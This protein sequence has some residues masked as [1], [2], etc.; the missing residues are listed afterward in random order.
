MVRWLVAAAA[1]VLVAGCGRERAKHGRVEV[2]IWS[3]WT[4]EEAKSFQTLVDDFNRR[5][6]GI[7][8]HNLGGVTDNTK[9]VRAITAGVPPDLF[10]VW[11]AADVGPLAH[12]G[13]VRDLSAEYR[14]SGLKDADFVPGALRLCRDGNRLI[15]LPLLLDTN[16]LLWNKAAFRAA[17]L[18]PDRPPRTLQELKDHA[19]RLTKKDANGN[20]TQLGLQLPSATLLCWVSGGDFL[21]PK[22]GAVTAAAPQNIA[23]FQYYKDLV[24]VMGGR[25]SVQAF[26]SGFGQGQGPNNPFFVGKV[27]MMISGE[28]IPSWI[29]KYA[30]KMEYGVAP[31][32]YDAGHP[33]RK[34]T[35]LIAVNLLAVPKEAKHPREAWEFLRWLQR[36]EVQVRFAQALNNVPNIRAALD[37]P[38]LTTGSVRKEKFGK[39]CEIA[40]NPNARGFPVT[41][42][43]QFYQDELG[44]AAEFVL[45]GTKSPRQALLDVQ[46]KVEAEARA[47]R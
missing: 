20:I 26:G 43:S 44:R 31:V 38:A 14:A 39:F 45:Y 6:P 41:P 5:H 47:E 8:V 35:T 29:E 2:D 27:A 22:T 17:G 9:I 23:A 12:Y 33:E 21:N 3:G 11:N 15:G 10:T 36:P 13:A 24:T 32:P 25:E 16:A 18:D 46:A 19:A 37:D 28:W 34:G 7:F 40:Q 4:G 1:C 42:L 30:P